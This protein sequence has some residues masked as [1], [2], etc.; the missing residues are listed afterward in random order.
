[1]VPAWRRT[2]SAAAGRTTMWKANMCTVDLFLNYFIK[3][4][5][6]FEISASLMRTP[7]A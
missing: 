7:D 6:I 5:I 3:L 1:M 2:G 4:H